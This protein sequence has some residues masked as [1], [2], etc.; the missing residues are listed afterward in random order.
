MSEYFDNINDNVICETL[1][2]I[3]YIDC[4]NTLQSFMY[5]NSKSYKG[6]KT[7]TI[8]SNPKFNINS[9]FKNIKNCKEICSNDNSTLLLLDNGYVVYNYDVGISLDEDVT[10]K[11]QCV[12]HAIL[13]LFVNIYHIESW[14][15]SYILYSLNGDIHFINFKNGFE[16]ACHHNIT[17]CIHYACLVLLTNDSSVKYI[18]NNDILEVKGSYRNI[19]GFFDHLACI[20]TTNTL[21]IYTLGVDDNILKY[22]QNNV[23]NANFIWSGN[24]GILCILMEYSTLSLIKYNYKNLTYEP[25]TKHQIDNWID[26]ASLGCSSGSTITV[27]KTYG[28]AFFKKSDCFVFPKEFSDYISFDRKTNFF[29]LD[30]TT[31]KSVKVLDYYMIIYLHTNQY[32]YLINRKCHPGAYSNFIMKTLNN[33]KKVTFPDKSEGCYI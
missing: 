27:F 3:F 18:Y 8:S 25:L 33:L 16:Y 17:K 30:H 10:Y 7:K 28:S 13:N 19:D 4:S 2:K 31:I 26:Y 9:N 32:V 11:D 14:T 1:H 20:T 12:P 23:L 15:Y 24:A 29:D 6:I 5:T 21:E 22:T